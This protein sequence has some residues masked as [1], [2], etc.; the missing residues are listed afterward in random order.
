MKK[1]GLSLV[2]MSSI[3][4]MAACGGNEGNTGGNTDNANAASNNEANAEENNEANANAEANENADNAEAAEDIS[5]SVSIDGSGTVYPLMSR[6]AEDYMTNVN[7]EVSVEVS[8]A[9]TSAGMQRYVQGETDFSNASREVKDEELE[10]ME[11]NGIDSMEF[12]V[13]LDGMTIVIHPENDWATEMTVEEVESIFI[14]GAV[15]DDDVVMWSD[16]NADWPEEEINT[17]GPN[18]NH[19]TYE[20]FVDELLD[21][22]PLK[23]GTNLQQEY[24]TLVELVNDDENGIGFFGFGYYEAN[25]DNLG[26]VSID[27]G[28][29]NITPALDNIDL[30]GDY[31]PYTRQVFTNLNLDSARENPAVKDFATHVFDVA[32]ELA[33]DAGFAPLPEDELEEYK[34][35]VEAI[36]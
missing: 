4:F 11:A 2:A 36:N 20:F 22:Q 31:A 26:V 8:R 17:Y 21:E 19:G 12:P 10:E 16:I 1:F 27:F 28:E 35:E 14:S 29:G 6:I 5:G 34:A 30:E 3:V 32:D 9:G 25:T 7:S 18:E 24:P 15:N 23:E 13:A 33:A